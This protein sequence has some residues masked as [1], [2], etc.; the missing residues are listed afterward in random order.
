VTKVTRHRPLAHSSRTALLSRLTS[1]LRRNPRLRPATPEPV[2]RTFYDDIATALVTFTFTVA[3]AS[4][5]VVVT[6]LGSF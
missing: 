2:M 4:V 6:T 5:S 3:V 1:G